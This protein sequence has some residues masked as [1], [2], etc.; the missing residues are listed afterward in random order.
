[1]A[2]LRNR[3]QD[4]DSY[5]GGRDRPLNGTTETADPEPSDDSESKSIAKD[6]LDLK[7]A[8][9]GPLTAQRPP[10]PDGHAVF[11]SP[12][13]PF[14][15]I[16]LPIL[17]AYIVAKPESLIALTI[18]DARAYIADRISFGPYYTSRSNEFPT[19]P[20]FVDADFE[21]SPVGGIDESLDTWTLLRWQVGEYFRG[22]EDPVDA[23][24]LN[25]TWVGKTR[26]V[27]ATRLPLPG[28]SEHPNISFTQNS[29]PYQRSLRLTPSP[30][31][32]FHGTQTLHH[33]SPHLFP[34]PHRQSH[35][36]PRPLPC[37]P[38]LAPAHQ[39][40]TRRRRNRRHL[41]SQTPSQQPFFTT[42][43]ENLP[44]FQGILACVP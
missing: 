34:L 36:R 1:M 27:A 35:P 15:L 23:G 8:N 17:L 13:L 25:Q 6:T 42:C 9:G 26:W 2:E 37:P 32:I 31:G 20:T 38:S 10:E 12:F 29:K 7:R 21:E 18:T 44:C 11:K 3:R 43:H 22:K 28:S 41:A 4:K 14:L 5:K 19:L 24:L 16:A 40:R 30:R 33:S 39:Q